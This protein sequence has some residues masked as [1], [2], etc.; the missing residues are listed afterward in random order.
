LAASSRQSGSSRWR[1]PD[2][3]GDAA[4]VRAN[5]I[6]TFAPATTTETR[7]APEPQ[8]TLGEIYH[9]VAVRTAEGWRQSRVETTPLWSTG[10]RL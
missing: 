6:A 2:L 3:R 10:T 7:T 8:F 5:L 4:D 1:V 9:F